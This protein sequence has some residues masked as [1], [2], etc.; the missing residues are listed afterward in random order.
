MVQAGRLGPVLWQLPEN[1]HRDDARLEGWLELLPA[2]ACTRSSSAM[3][4]GSCPQVMAR[5]AGARRGADDRRS[6]LAAVPVARGDRGLALRSLSLRLAG[7]RRQLL[8]D[9][10]RA[11][12]AA[13]RPVAPA[14][15]R[16][17]PT[18]TT[19]GSGFA[20]ANAQGA[21]AAA[22]GGSL[23]LDGGASTGRPKRSADLGRV[24]VLAVALVLAP[25][26]EDAR[27]GRRRTS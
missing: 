22:G 8:G 15:R 11:V 25:V 9:R 26:G 10:D 7:P 2:P 1:F 6:P 3:R 16:C 12:G 20:P 14:T 18:S 23:A 17:T 27:S 5:A 13:D 24:E 19:T 4:A 21:R